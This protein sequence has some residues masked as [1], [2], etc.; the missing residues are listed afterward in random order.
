MCRFESLPGLGDNR[1]GQVLSM[2]AITAGKESNVGNPRGGNTAPIEG[3]QQL[4]GQLDNIIDG[5]ERP[6]DEGQQDA[7]AVLRYSQSLPAL[8][9][10]QKSS[11]APVDEFSGGDFAY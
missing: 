1:G 6:L 2:K 10:E 8:Q 4:K 5:W 7:A 3:L 9:P 11:A